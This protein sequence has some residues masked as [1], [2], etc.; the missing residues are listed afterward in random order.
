[1]YFYIFSI[2]TFFFQFFQ[3]LTIFFQFF[4]FFFQFFQFFQFLIIKR[5]DLTDFYVKVRG[6][7]ERGE[8]GA[9]VAGALVGAQG[10]AGEIGALASGDGV[11][12]AAGGQRGVAAPERLADVA[13]DADQRRFRQFDQ[14]RRQRQLGGVSSGG[15]GSGGG[16]SGGGRHLAEPNCTSRCFNCSTRQSK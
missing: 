7:I 6:R 5:I 12:S 9:P 15:V 2:F 4:Q 3:F 10:N 11:A 13:T 14:R 8:R 1:M 16:V